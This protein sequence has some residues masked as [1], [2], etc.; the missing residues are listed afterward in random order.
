LK[1]RMSQPLFESFPKYSCFVYVIV[2]HFTIV[3]LQ[4]S[5]QVVYVL[6]CCS[7]MKKLG[8]SITLFYPSNIASLSPGSATLCEATISKQLLIAWRA[9]HARSNQDM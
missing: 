9:S 1:F 7:C 5:Y 6:E 2:Y 3:L 4:L 8:P